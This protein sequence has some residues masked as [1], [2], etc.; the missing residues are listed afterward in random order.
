MITEKN[1]IGIIFINTLYLEGFVL[2]KIF[3]DNFVLVPPHSGIKR[4]FRKRRVFP[5]LLFDP[6][7][8]QEK[9]MS[10]FF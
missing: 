4:G 5:G 2:N 1:F 6:L 7:N 3:W 10:I 9:Q 8:L